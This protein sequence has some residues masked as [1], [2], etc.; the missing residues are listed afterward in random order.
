MPQSNGADGSSM[1]QRKQAARN[2]AGA[3]R[4]KSGQGIDKKLNGPNRPST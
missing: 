4:N 2:A 3:G 1:E